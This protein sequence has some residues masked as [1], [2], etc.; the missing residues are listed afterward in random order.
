MSL[1]WTMEAAWAAIAVVVSVAG[2]VGSTLYHAGQFGAQMDAM[3]SAQADT[4]KHVKAHDRALT[5]IATQNARMEQKL[6]DVA[7]TVHDI[8]SH[9][10]E[11]RK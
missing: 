10:D 7:D 4:E 8:R 1:R 5:D 3:K 6:D 2:G 9:Q 11:K